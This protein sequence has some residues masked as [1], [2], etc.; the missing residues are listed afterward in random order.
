MPSWSMIGLHGTTTSCAQSILANGYIIPS[1]AGRRG[2]GVY[3]WFLEDF[4]LELAKEWWSKRHSDRAYAG[5]LDSSCAVLRNTITVTDENDVLSLETPTLNGMLSRRIKA[6][7][8]ARDIGKVYEAVV[9]LLEQQRN[10]GYHVVTSKVEVPDPK[11]TAYPVKSGLRPFCAV[12]RH[13]SC[14]GGGSRVA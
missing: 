8:S 6:H 2:R 13:V 1:E 4:G 3:F 11:N 5:H 10:R 14:I 12:V 7:H 9:Q